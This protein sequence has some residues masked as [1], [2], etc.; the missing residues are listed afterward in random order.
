MDKFDRIFASLVRTVDHQAPPAHR[1]AWELS[2]ASAD[3]LGTE[4]QQRKEVDQIH[5]ALSLPLLGV[6]QRLSPVLL[7]EQSIQSLL[8]TVWQLK[9]CQVVGYL[10]F[11]LDLNGGSHA[12]NPDAIGVLTL[13]YLFQ[14]VKGEQGR[15]VPIR[16]AEQLS[17]TPHRADRTIV[18]PLWRR[19]EASGRR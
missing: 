5:E 4:T 10:N 17:R 6:S 7:V 3:P 8:N 11:D 15:C 19:L 9:Q 2:G 13:V 12:R 18:Q 1:S 14:D 16:G